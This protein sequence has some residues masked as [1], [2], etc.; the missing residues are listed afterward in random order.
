MMSEEGPIVVRHNTLQYLFWKISHV[1][2]LIYIHTGICW[3]LAVRLFGFLT[4]GSR[5]WIVMTLRLLSFV[6]LLMPGWLALLRYYIFDAFII[7]N[8]EYGKG[9]RYRNLL[10]VYLPPPYNPHSGMKRPR[11]LERGVPVIVF[12]S[13]GAWIIGYK[14]WSALMG[15]EFARQGYVVIVPDYRNFPQGDIRDMITDLRNA[16]VWTV[17]NC[18]MFGGDPSKIV[19]SGQSAGAHI[20]LCTLVELY[21]E[22]LQQEVVPTQTT[23]TSIRSPE[24]QLKQGVN[25]EESM[26]MSR[27]KKTVSSDSQDKQTNPL[28]APVPN[29]DSEEDAVAADGFDDGY[30]EAESADNDSM[31]WD[32]NTPMFERTQ[33]QRSN[34]LRSSDSSEYYTADSSHGIVREPTPAHITPARSETS[35]TSHTYHI[36]T[37]RSVL[38]KEINLLGRTDFAADVINDTALNNVDDFA[39]NLHISDIQ[40]FVGI[41]GPYNMVRLLDHMHLRGLDASIL[42]HVFNNNVAKYSPVQRLAKLAGVSM[43]THRTSEEDD[44]IIRATYNHFFSFF[45]GV[46]KTEAEEDESVVRALEADGLKARKRPSAA[47]RSLRG[48]PTVELFHGGRDMSCP[49]DVCDELSHVLRQAS[50]DVRSQV[51]PNMSHTDP[52]LENLLAGETTLVDDIVG[53][54]NRKFIALDASAPTIAAEG[55]APVMVH[56]KLIYLARVM[57]PF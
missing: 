47:K 48:F 38:P 10:D 2:S 33:G 34:S 50:V 11:K 56:R 57:N 51:Y 18:E 55:E 21:E 27:K 37:H 9:G 30:S 14:L 39:H 53:A 6:L 25:S 22:S 23:S 3:N 35:Q 12:V 44:S 36:S 20:S 31:W 16:L 52:I 41:S 43:L 42:H 19:L 4:R 5:V 40:M 49:V 8:I 28:A 7:R 45:F 29:T 15:R 13:G 17:C 26:S 46:S 1:I 54:I 24:V 32:V